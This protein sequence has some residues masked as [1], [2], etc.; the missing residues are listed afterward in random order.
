MKLPQIS[1]VEPMAIN[2]RDAY[3][4]MQCCM[5]CE[6]RNGAT[7]EKS[8]GPIGHHV[9]FNARCPIGALPPLR[10]VSGVAAHKPRRLTWRNHVWLFFVGL[11]KLDHG[12]SGTCLPTEEV[13]NHRRAICED[14]ELRSKPKHGLLS[15]CK[16]CGCFVRAKVRVATEKCPKGK[17]DRAE[18]PDGCPSF[19]KRE[20]A[21]CKSKRKPSTK[22]EA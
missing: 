7:C 22:T 13:I 20:C 18:V 10:T 12:I 16:P 8:R 15:R 6:H 9:L 17:W 14:C 19:L 3:Q 2:A 4:R 11:A 1:H 5:T 21:T